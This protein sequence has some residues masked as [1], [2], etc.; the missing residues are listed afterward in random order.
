[1]SRGKDPSLYFPWA[2]GCLVIA[3][4]V[5]I[6]SVLMMPR[7]AP[8]DAFSRIRAIAP[9]GSL[10]IL[11]RSAP[12]AEIL[13]FNDPAMAQAVCRYD[14]DDGPFR[15]SASIAQDSLLS[16]SFHDRYGIVFYAMTDRAAVRGKIEAVVV[17]ASQKE[18]LE[19][20]DSEDGPPPE[21][22]LQTIQREGFVLFRALAEQPGDY[23][24]AEK[25]L[26]TISCAADVG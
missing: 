10:T 5:H 17:T 19:S 23:A 3:G 8:Q 26:Q 16:M 20:E 2:A 21:L 4:I 14:L 22:R 6:V 25:K 24:G 9:A 13:P 15:I 1:M 11:P 18:A 7:L 12:R